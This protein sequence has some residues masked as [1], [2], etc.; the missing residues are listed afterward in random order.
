MEMRVSF[1]YPPTRFVFEDGVA[2]AVEC[3]AP[4]PAFGDFFFNPLQIGD[5]GQEVLDEVVAFHMDAVEAD[6][7]DFA[8]E[9]ADVFYFSAQAAAEAVDLPGGETD[10]QQF[11]GNRVAVGEI[12]FVLSC[13]VF[14]TADHFVVFSIW[15]KW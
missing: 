3:V 10:F 2:E 7:A 12:V 1:P 5:F 11:V 13:G 6:V 15:A 4:N 14:Q 9:F 8:F